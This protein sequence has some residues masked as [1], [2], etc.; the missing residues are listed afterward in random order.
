MVRGGESGGGGG[1]AGAQGGLS[2]CLFD[3]RRDDLGE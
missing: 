1:G 3:H 2:V